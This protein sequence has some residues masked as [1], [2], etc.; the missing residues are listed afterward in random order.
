[1]TAAS[2]SRSPAAAPRPQQAASAAGLR[3]RH[4]LPGHRLAAWPAGLLLALAVASPPALAG[5]AHEHGAA[6]LDVAVEGKR[7]SIRLE[8]PL[9]SLLGFERR[10]RT[11]AERKAAAELLTRLRQGKG[12]FQPSP[13][14]QCT[15][16]EAT[17]TAPVLESAGSDAKG[18]HADLEAAY[19]F[20][21]TQPGQLAELRVDLFDSFK[22]LERLNVQLIG[23]SGQ[24]RAV[25]GPRSRV[26]RLPK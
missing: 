23:S 22:R 11:D 17:V 14:A 25:L 18:G 8:S 1:M 21:C 12:L 20:D 10:P 9:D 15:L 13:G 3:A 7:V 6:T 24:A 26:A 5:K 2:P 4:A 19:S 16:A